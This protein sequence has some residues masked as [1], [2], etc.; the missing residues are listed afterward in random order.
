MDLLVVPSREDNSPNVIGEALMSNV[1]VLGSLSGGIP[2]ILELFGCPV[3][4][5]T[6][7]AKFAEKL[8]MEI[9]QR[10]IENYYPLARET[11]GYKSIGI[12]M[13]EFYESCL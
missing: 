1:K 9:N 11:F 4:D 6:D 7:P 8:I 2:E 13:S 5:T 10:Q 12:Q 3:V